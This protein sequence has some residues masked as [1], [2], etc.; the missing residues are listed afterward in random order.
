MCMNL[1][2]RGCGSVPVPNCFR[3]GA[4][5]RHPYS[6]FSTASIVAVPIAS[7]IWFRV[8]GSILTHHSR[9]PFSCSAASL[10]HSNSQTGSYTRRYCSWS[11]Q[12]S[13]D[14]PQLDGQHASECLHKSAHP[15]AA[16]S[17][18]GNSR[19][20]SNWPEVRRPGRTSSPARVSPFVGAMRICSMRCWHAPRTCCSVM[21]AASSAS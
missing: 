13:G 15:N 20:Y 14:L 9:K 2:L 3:I 12:T 19:A 16:S 17:L 4:H 21:R 8:S 1:S 5:T 6:L 10:T 18:Y 7:R 11:Y